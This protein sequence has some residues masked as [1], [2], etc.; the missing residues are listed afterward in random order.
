MSQNH[1]TYLK[2]CPLFGLL[3]SGSQIGIAELHRKSATIRVVSEVA[4]ESCD[5]IIERIQ[6]SWVLD[7]YFFGKRRVEL[8]CG[9]EGKVA[10]AYFFS[11]YLI[12]FESVDSLAVLV[13]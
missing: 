9:D 8:C 6:I 12:D 13:D 4:G 5:T 1:P 11:G 7:R 3:S 2:G 10:F